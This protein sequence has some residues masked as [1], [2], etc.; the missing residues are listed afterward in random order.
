MTIFPMV[1]GAVIN[2]GE[3]FFLL[4]INN[5]LIN[6]S[7]S[8]PII[9]KK[10]TKDLQKKKL[11]YWKLFRQSHAGLISRSILTRVNLSC[12]DAWVEILVFL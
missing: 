10:I 12:K 1:S 3:F 2:Q 11:E 7:I 8:P 6:V 9:N 4:R 5:K